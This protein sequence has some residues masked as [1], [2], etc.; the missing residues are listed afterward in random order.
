MC[1]HT[2][3]KAGKGLKA[4]VA[5]VVEHKVL[6][7]AGRDAEIAGVRQHACAVG[8]RGILHTA[9][10]GRGQERHSKGDSCQRRFVNRLVCHAERCCS[11][12]GGGGG[13]AAAAAVSS[14]AVGVSFCS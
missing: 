4:P 10:G 12:C 5:A 8:H 1:V 11:C 6:R 13:G 3:C 14:T 9:T 2:H 7:L